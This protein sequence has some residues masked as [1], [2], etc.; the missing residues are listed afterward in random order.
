M[1]E[2]LLP[3]LRGQTTGDENAEVDAWVARSV[4][5]RHVMSD[6]RRMIRAGELAD[7]RVPA[8]GPPPSSEVVRR[9]EARAMR[10]LERGGSGAVTRVRASARRRWLI[11]G[12]AAAA[13]ATVAV[14]GLWNAN[15]G[16]ADGGPTA[17]TREYTTVA[18][19]TEMVRLVDGSMIRLGPE[20][21]FST[22]GGDSEREATLEGEA[23]FAIKADEAR[24]FRVVT[25]AG[26]AWVLGTRFHLAA[27]GE[28]LSIT[29][30]EGRVALAGPD[31]EVWVGSGQAT[32][33]VRGL[34]QAVVE[35]P[36]MS[37][38]AP[39]LEDYLVFLDTPLAVAMEEVEERYGIEVLVESRTLLDRTLTVWFH[40]KPLEEVMTVVCS[41][42]DARCTI[43]DR[44]VRMRASAGGAGS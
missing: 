3:Y 40:E 43:G 13:V 18:E 12:L 1:N 17:Q 28:E 41:V 26:T 37:T 6:L 16:S 24:P 42:V 38:I 20:S 2:L 34:P 32:S 14:L 25:K 19:E 15:T 36:P 5:N 33:L 7:R 10:A 39:W 27:L 22:G 44:V 29:V 9:A 31:S 11:G 4:D 21:R 8:G 23:F 30:V 35:A